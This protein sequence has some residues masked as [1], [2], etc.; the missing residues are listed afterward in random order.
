MVVT[1]SSHPQPLAPVG[2]LSVTVLLSLWGCRIKGIIQET[3][4]V[5]GSFHPVWSLEIPSSCPV[6]QWFLLVAE[7]C[8]VTLTARSSIHQL[9]G[10]LGCFQFFVIVNKTARRTLM[11]RHMFSFLWGQSIPTNGIAGSYSKCMF[12]FIRNHPCFPRGG[13]VP[14]RAP[15]A[16][17]EFLSSHLVTSIFCCRVLSASFFLAILIGVWCY[18]TV[19]VIMHF[20]NR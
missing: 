12:N 10:H 1:T 20:R 19:V 6:S 4:F 17:C 2:L 11:Y 7:S 18:L 16:R 9:R 15:P 5:T 13:E 3:P 14:F 8:S